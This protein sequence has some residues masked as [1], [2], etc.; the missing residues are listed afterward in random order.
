MRRI[1]LP[2]ENFP[3]SEYVSAG[4]GTGA[5]VPIAVMNG[6]H[7]FAKYFGIYYQYHGG[8]LPMVKKPTPPKT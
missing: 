5:T 4:Y 6:D 1:R 8:S 2:A 3:L 7:K